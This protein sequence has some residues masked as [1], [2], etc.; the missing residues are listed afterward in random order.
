[1][2]SRCPLNCKTGHFTS[3]KERECG[4][5]VKKCMCKA[6][7]KAV[8]HCQICKLVGFLLP[9]SSWLLK[10][11][12]NRVGKYKLKKYQFGNKT[13]ESSTNFRYLMTITNIPLVDFGKRNCHN[14]G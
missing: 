12:N 6:C 13:K 14:M 1:M 8:F 4:Q 3:K 2:P 11:P 9:S 10:L 5:N 7:K